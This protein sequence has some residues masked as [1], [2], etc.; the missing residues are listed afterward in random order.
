ML[1][2]T[3][4]SFTGNSFFWFVNGLPTERFDPTQVFTLDGKPCTIHADYVTGAITVETLSDQL[5]TYLG[6]MR[7]FIIG[8]LPVETCTCDLQ[9]LMNQGCQ[10]GAMQRE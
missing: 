6:T 10:C 1:D 3:T 2:G 9:V 5:Y 4:W 8:L 7:Y